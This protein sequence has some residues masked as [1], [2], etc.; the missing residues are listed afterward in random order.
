MSKN[1]YEGTGNFPFPVDAVFTW[2]DG[3]DPEWRREKKVRAEAL[4]RERGCE[5]STESSDDARFRDNDELRFAFRSLHMYAPW[6][7]RVHLVTAN[8]KPG[9]LNTGAVNLVSHAD[10]FPDRNMLPVFSTRPIELCV[11]R[12]P[13]LAEHFL[14]FNDDFLLGRP[15]QP[16]HFFQPDGKPIVWAVRQSKA[17]LE[18]EKRKTTHSTHT[19]AIL[20]A[21]AAVREKYGCEFPYRMR[22]FPKAMTVTTAN[23]VWQQFPQEVERTLKNPFRS[24][25]DISI[26]ALYPL[27]LLATGKGR[28]RVVN[29][30]RQIVDA[31]CGGVYHMGASLGDPNMA[32]K[33]KNIRLLRPRTLCINDSI[34][35]SERDRTLLC[36]TM[37][38]LFPMPSP[39]E[40]QE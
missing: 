14:Y 35:A 26:T 38:S 36:E 30:V 20:N 5:P 2:V 6:I 29:G 27:Y 25:G 32:K 17:R 10:I 33:L 21:C 12:I 18:R 11:H 24:P 7:R 28:V 23:E 34:A 15:L 31:L 9:W 37:L 39:F 8:Q 1:A 16:G 3:F 4:S 19:L 40:M 22:H 13:G